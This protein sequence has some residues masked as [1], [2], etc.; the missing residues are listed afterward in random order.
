[1]SDEHFEMQRGKEALRRVGLR[2]GT[3]LLLAT[4]LLHTLH[5][6]YKIE[7]TL[8]GL[9]ISLVSAWLVIGAAEGFRGRFGKLLTWAPLTYLGAI[10]YGIYIY[11]LPMQ[12]YLHRTLLQ[13]PR[14]ID[15]L[16]STALTICLAA[17]SWHFFESP[18]NNLKRHFGYRASGVGVKVATAPARSTISASQN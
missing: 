10:S 11:H 7:M 6:G 1:M 9:A 3:P 4:L 14:A 13:M 16:V 18:I 12:N 15:A 8:Q 17:L 5:R 2:L